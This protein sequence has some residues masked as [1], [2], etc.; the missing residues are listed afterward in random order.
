[1]STYVSYLSDGPHGVPIEK[2]RM[3]ASRDLSSAMIGAPSDAYAFYFFDIKTFL[4]D[5]GLDDDPPVGRRDQSPIY[6]I[7][8]VTMDMEEMGA[9]WDNGREIAVYC[10]DHRI[11]AVKAENQVIPI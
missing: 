3:V 2:V 1:M 6:Y 9:K 7:D 5:Y 10:W 4:L 8:G 11:R